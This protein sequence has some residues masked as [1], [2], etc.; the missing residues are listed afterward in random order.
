[1]GGWSTSLTWAAQTGT[2]FSISPNISTAA[3]GGA[4]ATIVRDPYAGGGSPD[5]SNPGVT[6]PGQVHNKTNWFNPCALANPLPGETISDATHPVGSVN[7]DGVPVLFEGP[8]RD[9]ATAIR[10]LGGLQ[11]TLYGPGYNRLNMSL[12]KT[13][14]VWREQSLQF[15]ADA[16]NLLNHPT[17]GSPTNSLNNNAG[18]ITGPQF[19]Q[20]NTP[21]ARFFQLS[22]KYVF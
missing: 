21:D 19:F 6:C 7:T 1:M 2:P 22:L 3:G 12:F 20:N 14:P 8:V 13:F 18:Q 9:T 4:R 11:D 5:P 16:F 15:R 10:L 17:L